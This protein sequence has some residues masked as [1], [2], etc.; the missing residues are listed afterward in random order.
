[1]YCEAFRSSGK[2]VIC[3][4]KEYGKWESTFWEDE[5]S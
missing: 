5:S 3:E 2:R 4:M 1:M